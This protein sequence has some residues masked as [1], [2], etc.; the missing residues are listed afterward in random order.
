M[1]NDSIVEEVR[2]SRDEIASR[3]HYDIFALGRYFQERQ[4]QEGRELISLPPRLSR[5]DTD[6]LPVKQSR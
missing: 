1:I 3:F 2:K 5:N 4:A 6:Q